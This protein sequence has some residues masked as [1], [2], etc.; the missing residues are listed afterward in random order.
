[1]HKLIRLSLAASLSL[2]ATTPAHAFFEQMIAGMTS[3]TNNLIDSSEHVAVSGMSTTATTVLVLSGDIGKMA[4]RI[5]GMADKIG[6][7]ADRIGTMADR[8]VLTES[9]MSQFAHKL[10]DKGHDLAVNRSAAPSLP[11][12]YAG[13]TLPPEPRPAQCAVYAQANDGRLAC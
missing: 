6:L 2:L 11:A 8:I 12:A 7:M 10:V 1:M 4:D 5:N 3:V 13:G 9:M